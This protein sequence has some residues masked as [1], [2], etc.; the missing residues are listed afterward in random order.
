MSEIPAE[1]R[2][3]DALD[4][5][6]AL[7]A[8][9]DGAG[10]EGTVEDVRA[11]VEGTGRHLVAPATIR[12][13]SSVTKDGLATALIDADGTHVHV[14]QEPDG[15]QI[16]VHSQDGIGIVL[17]PEELEMRVIYTDVQ[18]PLSP[19]ADLGSR[20]EAEDTDG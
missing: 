4:Q 16:M 15:L 13:D 17:K 8:G 10:F 6:A 12:T 20:S 14:T 19:R 7:F 18:C 2:D 5:I 1:Q 11:I 9:A 3:T